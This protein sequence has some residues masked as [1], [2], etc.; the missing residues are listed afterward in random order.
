MV[1]RPYPLFQGT[2]ALLQR[3]FHAKGDL[4]LLAPNA[5]SGASHLTRHDDD[6]ALPWGGPCPAIPAALGDV[7]GVAVAESR[8]GALDL[9]ANLDGQLYHF[10]QRRAGAG[11]AFVG[12][13]ARAAPRWQVCGTPAIVHSSRGDRWTVEV[14]TPLAQGEMSVWRFIDDPDARW[15]HGTVFG[16]DGR[17]TT[18]VTMIES[19][20]GSLEVVC[21]ADS[22]LFHFW[23]DSRSGSPWNGPEAVAPD[24]QV[25]GSPALIQGSFGNKGHFELVVGAVDGGLLHFWRDN[26]AHPYAWTQSAH[27]GRRLD[28]TGVGLSQVPFGVDKGRLEIVCISGG[29]LFAFKGSPATGSWV[30]P[31]P[32]LRPTY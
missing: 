25:Q 13:L 21:V 11:P 18:A 5:A 28:V 20:F 17:R 27:F 24:V 2:L 4:E 19:T 30:G 3:R 26:D 15:R 29:R 12:P 8:S 23:R 31:A 32:L 7:H 14:V 16:V 10:A 1:R 9:V 22:R 6:P